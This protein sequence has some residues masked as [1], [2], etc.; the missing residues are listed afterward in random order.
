[1]KLDTSNFDFNKQ[2]V[3]IPGSKKPGQTAIYRNS[4]MPNELVEKPC[5]QVSTVFESFQ[6]AAGKYANNPCLGYRPFNK[7]TGQYGEYVW[8]TYKETLDRF[9]NLGSGLV[10]INDTIVKNGK[11]DKYPIGVWS[12]NK[13][14]FQLIIQANAAYNLIT[15]PLYDTL[16]PDTI[17]YCMNHAE[18]QIVLMTANHITSMLKF[19]TKIPQLRVI[20]SIDPLEDSAKLLREWAS[21]LNIKV[22]EFSEIE[23]LGKE[24]PRNYNPPTPNDLFTIPY[25]SGTT[26][27]PKGVV[28]T[29]K[30]MVAVVASIALATPITS[31]DV[32]ISYLPLAHIFGMD[33]ELGFLFVG[34]SIGY[35]RGD[36][37][38]IFDDM[39]VL[40][41]TVFPSVPRIFN[42][43]A[44]ILK[45]YSVDSTGIIGTLARKAIN[46]KLENLEKTGSVTHPI[47]DRLFLNKFKAFFGGRIKYF[48]TGGAPLAKDVMDFLKVVFSVSFQEGY[49]QSEVTGLGCATMF[50]DVQASHVGPPVLSSELKLVDVPEMNY[51]SEDKPFPR[52]EI[53]IRGAGV[54]IGYYKDEKKTKETIDKDGWLHSGDI[55]YI[56]ARGCVV[57]ID[58]KSSIFKLA[59]GEY[60]AP[61]KIE[62]I[63]LRNLLLAQLF[64]YGEPI[65]SELVGIAVP[66]P[67]LFVPWAN[68]LLGENYEFEELVKNKKVCDALLESINQVGIK[69]GLNGFERIKAVYVEPKPFSPDDGIITATFKTKRPAMAK[70]YRKIIN[71]LYADLES[72]QKIAAKL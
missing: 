51:T 4:L 50:G 44:A 19:A 26:G 32:F 33:I 14:E 12:I 70:F 10:H 27:I 52:G 18:I 60:I 64:V 30:N 29:H 3:I 2:T 53:C 63:Y 46:D 72:S 16:G 24:N 47:W 25:T 67:E 56:D 15:V 35:Y 71:Q 6:Y 48:S 1:M 28:I 57:I 69:Y 42:R 68:K 55:G 61:E 54:M 20:I 23:K 62:Q 7:N 41:P 65:R 43:V 59:Q 36:I 31:D 45:S 5:P 21:E 17:E 49:G 8:E 58:R 39:K 13:P 66:N 34:C 22:Y 40:K 11:K 9:T 37:F 38:G